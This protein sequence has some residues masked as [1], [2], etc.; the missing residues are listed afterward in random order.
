MSGSAARH[1][2]PVD[3]HLVLRREGEA[4]PEVLLSRRAGPVY[5]SGLWHL[6]SGHLDPGEDMVEAVIREAR[7]ETGVLIDT[8]D[9]A[10]AATVHHRPPAGTRSRIG[11]FFEVRRWSGRPQVMEP[12]RCDGMGWYPLDG[13]PDPMVAYCRAGLDAYRAGLPAAVHF[14]RPEDPVPHTPGHPD[15]TRLLPGPP[16]GAGAM[17]LP[18]RLR[19]FAEQAVGRI[20]EAAEVSWA[21]TRNRVWRITGADGGVWYLKRH[22]TARFHEREVAAYR[23]WVPALGA[24]APRLVAADTRARA[25][26]ITALAGRSPNGLLLDPADEVRVQHE[27]G[28]LTS[29]LHRC[30]PE[31]PAGPSAALGRVQRHLREARPHL[32]DGDE[33]LVLALARVYGDLPQPLSVPTHG[34]LQYRNVLLAEDGELRL[35]D[36]ERSE[37]ATATRD[38]ARLSDTWTGRPD[39]RA[40]FL[41]GYGRPLTPTEELRLDC[42]TAFDAVSGI[43]YGTAHDDPEV[44]ERGRR[45]LLRLHTAR[46]P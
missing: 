10:A 39:L 22:R 31:R 23:T 46:R 33:D 29:A 21:R 26:V 14:Q 36:F 28:R 35:F 38:M 37:Y 40:A 42:E 20:T 3:V 11:V 15:R 18:Y 4:G 27:L 41:D 2:V 32:A 44:A 16:T 5:A 13:L 25:V 17:G 9:V 6:P 1:T 7:E 43:A 19:V 24:R 34:D 45:T 8:E 12:D 30:G